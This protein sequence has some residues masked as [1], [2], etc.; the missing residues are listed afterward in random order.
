MKYLVRYSVD[1]IVEADSIDEAEDIV[2]GEIEMCSEYEWES[3]TIDDP[4]EL[5]DD[6]F[7]E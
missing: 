4:V 6:S 2:R 7:D 3:Y 5:D 1:A